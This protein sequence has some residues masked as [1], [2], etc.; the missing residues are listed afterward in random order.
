M[1]RKS[2]A[3]LEAQCKALKAEARKLKRELKDQCEATAIY[4]KQGLID[5][6]ELK[7][8]RAEIERQAAV[9]LE[10]GVFPLPAHALRAMEQKQQG[11]PG[12]ALDRFT[13][14]GV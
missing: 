6:D 12:V 11:Q 2:Q 13:R 5:N 14:V 1:T 4:Q 3:V 10:K 7:A 8:A 9:L